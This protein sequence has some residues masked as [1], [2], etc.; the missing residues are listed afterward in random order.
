MVGLQRDFASGEDIVAEG[1]DMCTVVFPNADKKV[2][3]DA[4]IE[5]RAK[6]R[7]SELKTLNDKSGLANVV[8]DIKQ[9]D[10]RD[11]TREFAPLTKVHDAFYLDTTDL[12]V[13]EVVCLLIKEI[14]KIAK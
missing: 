13:D 5:E 12:K 4:N 2:Y 7:Y 3:L 14:E 6:R 11:S 1:R 10:H 9:R 8:D